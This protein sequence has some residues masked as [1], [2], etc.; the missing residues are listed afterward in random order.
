M[1]VTLVVISGKQAGLEIPVSKRRILIG[2]YDGCQ[3]RLKDALVSGFHALLV[4][5]EESLAIE[6]CQSAT[7]TFVN[8]EYI[9][10]RRRLSNGD[11]IRIGALVLE[12]RAAG[13]AHGAKNPPVEPT[14]DVSVPMAV[15]D[16]CVTN[17]PARFDQQSPGPWAS[18]PQPLSVPLALQHP[19]PSVSARPVD[20]PA[21]RPHDTQENGTVP[22][23]DGTQNVGCR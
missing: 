22:F 13:S 3:I 1:K 7:G 17:V 16:D 12:V 15:V 6:D 18:A 4:L 10:K 11:R 9:Q 19:S 21:F 14:P 5:D 20:R 23:G 2:R 8:E